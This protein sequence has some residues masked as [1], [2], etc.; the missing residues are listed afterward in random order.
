MNFNYGDRVGHYVLARVED[1]PVWL[2]VYTGEKICAKGDPVPTEQPKKK[3]DVIKLIR[4]VRPRMSD[5]FVCAID[6]MR[7]TT[8][9]IELDYALRQIRYSF[10]SCEGDNFDKK[11]GCYIARLR[12]DDGEFVTIPM[13]NGEVSQHGVLYDIF[14]SKN[15]NRIVANHFAG[16]DF[17]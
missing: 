12:Y 13:K 9:Y 14:K 6:N 15:Y 17:L 8:F 1:K 10:A 7:G 16:A 3:P 2:N 5:V 11:L 4:F